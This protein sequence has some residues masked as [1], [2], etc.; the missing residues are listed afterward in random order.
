MAKRCRV[1]T[2][3]VGLAV[4][5]APTLAMAEVEVHFVNPRGFTDAA[6]Y[7]LGPVD[8][9]APALVGLQ[10]I[11][12]RLGRRLPPG[13][14]LRVE[15]LDVD[16]AGFFPPWLPAT[17]PIRVMEPTTWPRIRLRYA[18][19]QDGRILA[20]GEETVTDMTYQRRPAVTRSAAPLR[21][22]EPMLADWFAERFGPAAR[23]SQR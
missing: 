23:F 13:Q 1:W 16:L 4:L 20:S 14:D 21:F 2:A 9:D 11:F 7:R 17:P 6:L 15:I 22:E 3:V 12:E 18:L 19:V 10:R 8:Q 5:V